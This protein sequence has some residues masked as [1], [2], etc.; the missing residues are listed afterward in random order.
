M[1]TTTQEQQNVNQ[2]D[3]NSQSTSQELSPNQTSAYDNAENIADETQIQQPDEEEE[4]EIILQDGELKFSDDFFG[5]LPE[6]EPDKNKEQPE[7]QEEEQV[8]TQEPPANFYTDE[9]L[10]NTNWYQWDI[11]RLPEAVRPYAQI[12]QAQMQT[13]QRQQQVQEQIALNPEKPPYL[14]EVKPYTAQELSAEAEKLAVKQL[15]LESDDDFDPYDGEHV[16]ARNMAMQ[17]LLQ[18][19]NAQ[20]AY[21]NQQNKDYQLLRQVNRQIET[22]PDFKEYQKWFVEQTKRENTTPEQLEEALRQHAQRNGGDYGRIAQV[23]AGWYKQF[24]ASQVQRPNIAQKNIVKPRQKVS[25]PPVLEGT[26]G[27]YQGKKTYNVKQFGELD[28]DQQAQALM[29]MGIV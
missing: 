20:V 13:A 22:A 9:E 18:K 24:K 26:Q 15:G 10:R 12:I 11:Q 6:D 8:Q 17:E 21:Y 4:H 23:V 1:E 5:E 29:D 3:V 19:R 7:I 2:Q 28:S 16:A 27:G 25:V 14:Q